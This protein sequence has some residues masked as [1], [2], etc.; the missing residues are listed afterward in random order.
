MT[1][2]YDF[3]LLDGNKVHVPSVTNNALKSMYEYDDFKVLG[4]PYLRG[5]NEQKFTMYFFLPNAKDDLQF[6]V[7]KTSST[8]DFIIDRHIVRKSVLVPWFLIPVFKISFG[9]KFLIC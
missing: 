3:H 8:P 2:E 5:D 6:L 1:K 7:Q 9:C 4:L